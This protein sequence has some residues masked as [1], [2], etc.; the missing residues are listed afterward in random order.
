M[1]LLLYVAM[2]FAYDSYFI[3]QNFYMPYTY[4]FRH[5]VYSI[6]AICFFI[7]TDIKVISG[8]FRYN[9]LANIYAVTFWEIM[10]EV[11]IGKD[12]YFTIYYS[13]PI[14]IIISVIIGMYI[15]PVRDN[16]KFA[17]YVKDILLSIIIS[18][19]FTYAMVI[20]KTVS[21]L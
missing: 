19:V 7:F 15:A 3:Y 6:L 9:A 21:L 12:Y 18:L 2:W 10:R 8:R 13:F 16:K 1:P 17:I 5:V 11:S 14:V 20:A 4:L